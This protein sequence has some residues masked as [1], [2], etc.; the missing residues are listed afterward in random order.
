MNKIL[1]IGAFG[2]LGSELTL[3]L[4][5]IYGDSNV[6]ASDISENHP[7]AHEGL[8]ERIDVLDYQRLEEVVDKYEITQ[9]YNLAAILSSVG[10][11]KP[12]LAWDLNMGGLMNVLEI[13]RIKKLDKIYW[14]SSMAVFGPDTPKANTPQDTVTNPTTMYGISKLAGER[15]CEYYYN[16]FGVDVRSIRYPGLIGYKAMPGGGTTDYAVDIYFKAVKGEA[17]DCFLSK[18]EPLPMMYMNDAVRGTIELMEAPAK[19]ITIRTSYNMSAMSFDPEEIEASIQR[20]YPD[21]KIGYAPDH[22][23]DIAASWPDSID[24]QVARRDWAWKEEFDLNA[25]SDDILLN[26]AKI[27]K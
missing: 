13:A 15:L 22:R 4:R 8:F 24:D 21:F 27:L 11:S 9:I 18:G 6:I 10:E 17:F 5:K 20:H 26:L 14:P 1:V 19:N 2:Q 23:Q 16:K 25:M 12:K 7:L 3:E